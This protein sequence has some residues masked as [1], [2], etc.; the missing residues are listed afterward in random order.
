MAEGLKTQL[1]RVGFDVVGEVKDADASITIFIN[2]EDIDK[3]KEGNPLECTA[4]QCLQRAMGGSRVAMFLNTAYVQ[5]PAETNVTRYIVPAK[6]RD[7][8]VIP[9]DTGG[10]PIPGSYTLKQPRGHAR[11]GQAA[12][13]RSRLAA[14]R[15]QGLAPPVRK[16][17]VKAPVHQ[18]RTR[19]IGRI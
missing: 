12:A 17:A 13:R 19:W 10:D 14:L 3:G 4:A 7:K 1:H 18:I 5:L 16:L 2:Q 11:L 15:S 6:L 8:V 9:Q